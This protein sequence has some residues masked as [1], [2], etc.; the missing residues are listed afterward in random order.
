MITQNVTCMLKRSA[1]WNYLIHAEL[2]FLAGENPEQTIILPQ[3]REEAA[4]YIAGLR[5]RL[6]P[7][8][9]ATTEKWNADKGHTPAPALSAQQKELFVRNMIEVYVAKRATDSE[10]TFTT[11]QEMEITRYADISQNVRILM[12]RGEPDSEERNEA[13]YAAID[14][15]ELVHDIV[16]RTIHSTKP[17]KAARASVPVFH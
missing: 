2:T 8:R 17:G 9:Q 13:K 6:E 1:G 4:A 5:G 14:Y 3:T 11:Q 7:L 15:V 12:E 16:E 10:A